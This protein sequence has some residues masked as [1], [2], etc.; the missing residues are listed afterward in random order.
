MPAERRQSSPRRELEA[1]SMGVAMTGTLVGSVVGPYGLPAPVRLLVRDQT[2]AVVRD[3]YPPNSPAGHAG[4]RFEVRGLPADT[5]TLEVC[6]PG[7]WRAVRHDVR[8]EAS[9]ITDVGM[10]RLMRANV[11]RIT[12]FLRHM[13]LHPPF[14]HPP[15]RGARAALRRDSAVET[16]AARDLSKKR[17]EGAARTNRPCW[18]RGSA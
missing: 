7:F 9:R 3:C 8:V 11:P 17:R 5:Y 10:M 1:E 14:L 15:S 4:V 18:V 13:G 6:A 12:V 2:R 16:A